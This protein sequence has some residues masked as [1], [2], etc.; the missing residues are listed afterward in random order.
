MDLSWNY[1][2]ESQ[3][4]NHA[5]HI[6][7][8]KPVYV[9][10]LVVMD[11]IEEQLLQL[12]DVKTGLYL[13]LPSLTL[14]FRSLFTDLFNMCVGLAEAALGEGTGTKLNKL[15]VKDIKSVSFLCACS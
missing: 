12:Q 15:S 10:R 1:A 5:H 6:G 4:Y 11:M 2:A 8:E 14:S 7:Q 3:A 13:T 9:K